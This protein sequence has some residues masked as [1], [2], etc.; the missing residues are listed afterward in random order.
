MKTA[1][2]TSPLVGAAAKARAYCLKQN[3][4]MNKKTEEAIRVLESQTGSN[5]GGKGQLSKEQERKAKDAKRQA[6]ATRKTADSMCRAAET[7]LANRDKLTASWISTNKNIAAQRSGWTKLVKVSNDLE[8]KVAAAQS[9]LK[10]ALV[11]C[12]AAMSEYADADTAWEK[13]YGR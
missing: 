13:V 10:A 5:K 9:V 12:S 1:P 7:A 3:G 8:R 2:C 4:V 6:D 11:K